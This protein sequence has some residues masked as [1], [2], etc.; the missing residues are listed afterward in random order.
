MG[1]RHLTVLDRY[2]EVAGI[3]TRK[4][5]MGF[6]IEKSI[7]KSIEKATGKTFEHLRHDHHN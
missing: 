5:L 6:K 4:D 3:I 1:L 7:E 2:A